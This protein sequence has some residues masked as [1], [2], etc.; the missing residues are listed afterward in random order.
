MPA[1][2]RSAPKEAKVTER[3]KKAAKKEVET[4]V[5]ACKDDFQR[6]CESILALLNEEGT[7][8]K[9]S[10]KDMLLA[11]AP[12]A[13]RPAKADRHEF[14][15]QTVKMLT[16]LFDGVKASNIETVKSSESKA[17]E[18]ETEQ[19][20]LEKAL[21]DA[22]TAEAQAKAER[23]AADKAMEES[24]EGVSNAK[25]EKE[26]ASKQLEA[27]KV[28]KEQCITEKAQRDEFITSSWA[29]LKECEFKGAELRA[30]NKQLINIVASLDGEESLK[31]A[32]PVALKSKPD[33]RGT[34]GLKAIE[35]AEEAL[36][37]SAKDMASR[38]E[39]KD[40]EI[41]KQNALV[42]EK[43]SAIEAAQSELEEKQNALVN[44]ENKLM[45]AS[46]DI[47]T[48]NEALQTMG[49]T[50]KSIRDSLLCAQEKFKEISML[51]ERFDAIVKE[52]ELAI[53]KQE[54]ATAMEVEETKPEE[55]A[56]EPVCEK[57]EDD[58]A[59]GIAVEAA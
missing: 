18:V 2:K 38:I 21:E 25:Q 10:A 42:V 12:F 37:Q 8:I 23:D 36:L 48:K 28:E 29:K 34:I 50:N 31:M 35:F 7:T 49:N 22:R 44:S 15:D 27:L 3:S 58:K 52:G 4:N 17:A 56:P 53:R 13:L 51:L 20:S 45:Q 6:E 5:A 19:G 32:L 16:D 46:E 24:K 33:Q 40:S 30:R 59:A 14:Q 39:E 43:T 55:A 11:A 57:A 41:E 47:N 26:D 9:E 1:A 54:V